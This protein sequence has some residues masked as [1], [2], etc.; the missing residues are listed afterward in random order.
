MPSNGQQ[1]ME[2]SGRTRRALVGT[3]SM[4]GARGFALA[5]SF[6]SIGLLSRSL[7]PEAFGLWSILSSLAFFGSSLD[8]GLGQGMRNEL[9]VLAARRGEAENER[10]IFFSVLYGL[11]G[12]AVVGIAILVVARPL[13]P[14]ASWLGAQGTEVADLVPSAAVIVAS[15]FVLSMP[16]NL[17]VA[18][19]LAYQEANR[20]SAFDVLQSSFLLV[21]VVLFASR[22]SFTVFISAYYGLYDMAAFAGLLFFIRSRGWTAPRLELLRV[23]RT[24]RPLVVSS[25]RFWLLGISAVLI[26]S[27][28]PIIAAKVL[29]L[30]EAG[31]FSVVQ[32]LFT[33]LITIH[34]T[35]LTPL[36][37][38]YTHA[39]ERDDW[40]WIES[41]L[42]RSL[43]ITTLLVGLGTAALVLFS[44]PLLRVWVGH[45][46]HQ[47]G[48]V[49]ALAGWAGVYAIAN[50]Y[51]VVLNGLG[52]IRRQTSLAVG[53]AVLN[54][55]L[56]LWLG[57]TFGAQ[58]I[59]EATIIVLVPVAVSNYLQVRAILRAK[60]PTSNQ[61]R[62]PVDADRLDN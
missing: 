36:W 51:S 18:G 14:W 48:L 39:A 3:L 62:Q 25:I 53:A 59:V 1:A 20:R 11:T 46:I 35:V 12:F 32:K 23:I 5:A 43:A 33:L 2:S 55:P 7:S 49:L 9:A 22:S 24:I 41:A 19:F 21:A 42:K 30:A 4:L 13:V 52:H 56:S 57:K 47:T 61:S 26:F 45:E 31:D 40:A 58:G 38:A 28:D 29:G 15:L 17:N 6:V 10:N 27:S 50:C 8:L 16:L 60:R 54:W 34:F 37:S 44:R